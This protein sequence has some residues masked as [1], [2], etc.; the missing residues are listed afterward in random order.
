MSKEN[1]SK[2][3]NEKLMQKLT[4]QAPGDLLVEKYLVEIAKSHN[5][6]Y[7]PKPDIA[8]RDPDFFYSSIDYNTK[9][10]GSVSYKKRVKETF[11]NKLY[12]LLFNSQVMVE[13]LHQFPIKEFLILVSNKMF[14]HPLKKLRKRMKVTI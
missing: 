1:R 12:F 13:L 3:V 9:S 10:G 4:E 14:Y 11:Q 6:A 8:V 7:K 2:Q 5:V